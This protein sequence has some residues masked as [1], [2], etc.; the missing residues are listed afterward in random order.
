MSEHRGGRIGEGEGAVTGNGSGEPEAYE[1]LLLS[2]IK[3]RLASKVNLY[4]LGVRFGKA[5]KALSIIG[6]KVYHLNPSAS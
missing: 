1:I 6:C 2:I 3:I 5:N 4:I